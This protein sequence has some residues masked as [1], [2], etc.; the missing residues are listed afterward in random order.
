MVLIKS[1]FSMHH[2]KTN[3]TNKNVKT[4]VFNLLIFIGFS[5]LQPRG[6]I[7]TLKVFMKEL[8]VAK[9]CIW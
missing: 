2:L 5:L 3:L 8:L 6:N 9:V 7:P 4:S 1:N